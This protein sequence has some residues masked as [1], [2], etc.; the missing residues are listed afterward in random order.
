MNEAAKSVMSSIPDVVL[1]YGDS[2][3][4]SF[5]LKKN[6][7]LFE[8]REAKLVS[9]F[10]STFT[11]FYI[12]HWGNI[13]DDSLD[14]S[15]LP[16][17]DARAITYPSL[18][19]LRDYLSWRQADCHINNLYNTA[20]W[21]LVL[22]GKKSPQDAEQTL[23]G[24]V[25]STKNEILFSQFGINYNNEP[26]IFKKGTIIVRD[27]GPLS[28]VTT[29]DPSIQ[30]STRQKQRLTKK[31]NKADIQQ[32]HIDIIGDSFWQSRPWLSD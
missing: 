15:H 4:Y 11:A 28:S 21:A 31:Y 27:L 6:C 16:T 5:V 12:Q 10:A 2:D 1:A 13:M 17:F 22:K 32:L 25:A 20:F 3:E 19:I 26:E 18:L 9:T 30:L 23:C 14:V 24:T 29:P 8:R 7:L